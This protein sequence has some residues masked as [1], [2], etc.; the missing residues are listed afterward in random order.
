MKRLLLIL[1]IASLAI[2]IFAQNAPDQITTHVKNQKF[3]IFWDEPAA[4]DA[5][6]WDTGVNGGAIG[7]GDNPSDGGIAIKFDPQH[8]TAFD[9]Y[10][11]T[12]LSFYDR[13]TETAYGIRMNV[14][15]G[16]TA[17]LPGTITATD[18]IHSTQMTD[19]EVNYIPLT[20]PPT[21]DATQDLWIEFLFN[22]DQPD[23][24]AGESSYPWSQDDADLAGTHLG[25]G[26]L[27]LDIWSTPQTYVP[28]TSI[29][30]T[31]SGNWNIRVFLS[32]GT[33][34]M[35][36]L[37]MDTPAPTRP[38]VV[39]PPTSQLSKLELRDP[40]YDI[41][42]NA[43]SRLYIIKGYKVYKD[44]ALVEEMRYSTS[45]KKRFYYGEDV[46]G[47]H[48]YYVST[49]YEDTDTGS[50]VESSMSSAIVI[51]ITDA[52]P[53]T[54][55]REVHYTVENGNEPTINWIH[56][57]GFLGE[58]RL[59]LPG[60]MEQN[61]F[62]SG[63]GIFGSYEFGVRFD[64]NDLLN[65]V[66]QEITNV[67]LY[68]TDSLATYVCKIYE[69]G[70]VTYDSV[71]DEYIYDEGTCIHEEHVV[72]PNVHRENI[73]DLETP[74]TIAANTEYWFAFKTTQYANDIFPM[75]QAGVEGDIQNRKG[76]LIKFGTDWA[77]MYRDG[78]DITQER[79]HYIQIHISDTTT[80]SDN[81]TVIA[82]E[83]YMPYEGKAVSAL[84]EK[85]AYATL[86]DVQTADRANLSGW[87]VNWDLNG[88]DT[89]YTVGVQYIGLI[90]E[91][92]DGGDY[93]YS[94]TAVFDDQT[95]A[96]SDA[97]TC[98]IVLPKPSNIV[99]T[100]VNNNIWRLVWDAP[101]LDDYPAR[102]F[103]KYYVYS[104]TDTTDCTTLVD[105]PDGESSIITNFN[106]DG[107]YKVVAVYDGA[108]SARYES[109]GT[110]WIQ[111][112]AN[113][114]NN[115]DYMK[116]QIIGAYPNP[117]NPTT[118]IEYNI[119]KDSKVELVVYNMKGQKVRT[120]VNTDQTQ[121]QKSVVWDGDDDHGHN[122]G[123]GV[124]FYKLKAGNHTSTKKIVMM[125]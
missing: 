26:D 28:L 98:S 35:I 99:A 39:A 27:A 4:S 89:T 16:G 30:S 60:D 73:I 76:N 38:T 63:Y 56:P 47:Q 69:G 103:V 1:I 45:E 64:S 91:G 34:D 79:D 15:Q 22:C 51:D 17:S 112:H 7:F 107:A 40:D 21:I 87:I 41:Y 14:S 122:V 121:G 59:A 109:E 114:D 78:D 95:S 5:L 50:E 84:A 52:N 108:N 12:H 83:S 93:D 106:A 85:P 61:S 32:D 72:K 19:L 104:G 53:N 6:Y 125:K 25:Y 113:D 120:L 9:G 117:F 71:E 88:V 92:M 75:A 65:Y 68:A 90:L 111:N 97:Y 10:T 49:I 101:V 123:S 3:G 33:R 24:L 58:T 46:V 2:T 66:G 116:T 54:A 74:I 80:R 100:Q 20:T 23:T 8:L 67:R 48:N 36:P 118:T 96:T 57:G 42:D 11:I 37:T 62:N 44:A 18:T 82:P 86:A 70:S 13:D 29:A 102:G 77:S 94:V 119:A 115:I 124:Y 31:L 110:Y 43:L 55:P 105:E 81:H